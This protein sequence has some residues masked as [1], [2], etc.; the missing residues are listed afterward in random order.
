M[1]CSAPQEFGRVSGRLRLD[2]GR[3]HGPPFVARRPPAAERQGKDDHGAHARARKHYPKTIIKIP[4]VTLTEIK[5]NEYGLVQ[6]FLVGICLFTLLSSSSS[7]NFRCIGF[8]GRK[9][10]SFQRRHEELWSVHQFFASLAGRAC[11]HMQILLTAFRKESPTPTPPFP[12][13]AD[14]WRNLGH[15][16][17]IQQNVGRFIRSN[18]LI[19]I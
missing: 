17:N 1:I 3:R 15:G 13:H 19:C 18:V 8:R 14:F 5:S 16:E 12:C 4:N 10:K 7:I 6:S 9:I 2:C 11:P